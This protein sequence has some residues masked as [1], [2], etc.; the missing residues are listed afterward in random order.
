MVYKK[1]FLDEILNILK[2]EVL[3]VEG[4]IKNVYIDNLADV[5][6]VNATTLDWISP[7]KNNK[8]EIAEKSNATVLLVDESVGAIKGKILI[9]VRNPRTA[10][11]KVG[12]VFFVNQPAQGIH[13]TAIVSE[14]A[15]IGENV[16]I[17][18]YSVIGDAIIG[19]G[20]KISSH[21]R[22]YDNTVLGEN[23]IIK[24]GAVL[25]GTGFGF[26][27]DD[28]GNHFR[29]PQIGGLIIGQC[30]EIGANTCIDRG[31]LSDT[32][33]GDYTKI[34]NLVHIAHNVNI[35]KNAMI[36]ACSE[37]SGSCVIEDN[38]WIGP[39]TSVREWQHLGERVLTGIGS[40]IVKDVPDGEVWAGN[41][42]RKLK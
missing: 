25:G 18:P 33:I 2:S 11:A 17:G 12:N 35:G 37:I 23:C 28:D 32:E 1:V 38:A 8:Q 27:I 36:I 30:V 21:V 16:Y 26:E 6:H 5:K 9:K 42:A 41:P 29:F 20:C 19:D 13:K 22:I 7:S 40:V 10:L 14:N 39:N 31:A 15:K 4:E 34:D 24:E 3:E